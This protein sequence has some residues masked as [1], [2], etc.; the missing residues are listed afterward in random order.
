MD[1]NKIG[2]KP[3]VGQRQTELLFS[4]N[5]VGVLKFLNWLQFNCPFTHSLRIPLM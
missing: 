3:Y 2:I 5:G 4:N 1:E